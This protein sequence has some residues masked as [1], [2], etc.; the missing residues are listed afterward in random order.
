MILG[1]IFLLVF[2]GI[3]VAIFKWYKF[4]LKNKVPQKLVKILDKYSKS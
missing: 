4:L 2:I 1:F 3:L